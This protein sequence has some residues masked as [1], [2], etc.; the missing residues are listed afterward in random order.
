MGR[1][2]HLAMTGLWCVILW[3][4]VANA[5]LGVN[6]LPLHGERTNEPVVFNL[7]E[8]EVLGS[9]WQ[10]PR[11]KR[12]AA[13]GESNKPD[14]VSLSNSWSQ[15]IG[16]QPWPSSSCLVCGASQVLAAMSTVRE[17]LVLGDLPPQPLNGELC[18]DCGPVEGCNK[19]VWYGT[20]LP[21][22]MFY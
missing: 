20:L 22:T 14:K 5:H 6:R 13:G 18:E 15:N 12:A 16:D 4:C 9:E 8:Q 7:G 17:H 3:F 19:T 1:S 10:P 21:D 11:V 2:P